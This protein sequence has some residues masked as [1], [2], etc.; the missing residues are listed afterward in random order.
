[1]S[2]RASIYPMLLS[3]IVFSDVSRLQ[4]VDYTDNDRAAIFKT[5]YTDNTSSISQSQSLSFGKTMVSP[6]G[7]FELGFFNL[8]LPNKSYLGIWFK[9]NPSQNVV[10]V[11]NGGNPINDS[12]A[13]LRLNS[14]GNLV[15]THNNTV[16]WS[17]N[18]PK[19]AHNPV[20]ELL[21]FGNLVI[22][23]ENAANQEAY[24][25]Q[26]FDYPSDTMLSGMKIG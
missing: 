11:A 14:S 8:G 9:N 4:L 6:R 16:V 10:W 24:L 26:S 13:I 12:S 18:C 2:V 1:M 22:R 19:E 25:W 20:A 7:I 5:A 21:D 23:D 17:T 3:D 15:L